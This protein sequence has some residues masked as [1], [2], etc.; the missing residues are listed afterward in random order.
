MAP[1]CFFGINSK[2]IDSFP[3]LRSPSQRADIYSIAMTSF[4]V[5]SSIVNR[6]TMIQSPRY[7]QVLTGIL[8][9]D[10]RDKDNVVA[11][12]ALGKRPSRP[13]GQSQNQLLQD[14]I[15]DTITTC[16]SGKPRKRYKLSVVYSVFLKHSRR[17]AQNIEPGNS[18]SQNNRNFTI[19]E[20]SQ[21]L[22]RGDGNVEKSSHGSLLSSSF[23]EIQNQGSRGVL[24]KWIRQVLPP[25][26]L[27]FQ[28]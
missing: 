6:P 26:L 17:E 14:P 24:M 7:G 12:I 5:R 9:Y 15:W 18:D 25:L 10:G 19:A 1:E 27:A 4:N 13:N 23:C 8:P 3:S 22:K 16:W 21:A 28:G 2:D 20:G 11:D